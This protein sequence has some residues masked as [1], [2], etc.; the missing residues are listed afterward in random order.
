[1]L[2]EELEKIKVKY[3]KFNFEN[4]S[5]EELSKSIDFNKCMNELMDVMLTDL[6]K[7]LSNYSLEV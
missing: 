4:M 6:I 7:F 3:S 5:Y 2:K 1:M